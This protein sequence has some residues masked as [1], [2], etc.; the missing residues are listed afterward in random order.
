[1]VQKE[2]D[3]IGTFANNDIVH[4]DPTGADHDSF[5]F[6]LKKSLLNFMHGVGF[7][8]PLQKWF[9]FKVPKTKVAP[10]YIESALL[11]EEFISAKPTAKQVWIG[12]KVTTTYF[13]QS[14]KGNQREMATLTFATK[15]ETQQIQV[16][17][18]QGEWL[19]DV[20]Q[21]ISIT[22]P[23]TYTLQEITESYEAAGLEDFE[24]FWDN[25]PVSTMHKFGLLSL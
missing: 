3:A 15:K 9:E 24:L 16:P 12:H 23:N 8:E 1:L 17:K 18:E 19:T 2:T 25:K 5:S 10:T 22:N 11:K 13:T 7:D 21:K 4:I 14:K 6:G 20:L